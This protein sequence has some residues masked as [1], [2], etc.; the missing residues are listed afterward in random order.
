M[1][2]VSATLLLYSFTFSKH[3][4]VIFLYNWRGTLDYSDIFSYCQCIIVSLVL[5]LLSTF[6][7]SVTSLTVTVRLLN[8]C[9]QPIIGLRFVAKFFQLRRR[10]LK[11][12]SWLFLQ[13]NQIVDI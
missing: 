2:T 13:N 12:H 8:L 4:W 10:T 3:V 5:V 1:L 7:V 11:L 6:T 9:K